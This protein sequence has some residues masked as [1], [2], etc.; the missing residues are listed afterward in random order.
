MTITLDNEPYRREVTGEERRFL[1]SPAM[2]IS[3]VLRLRGSVSEEALKN[4]VDKMLITYPLFGARM[5]WADSGVHWSTTEAAAEVP[6]KTYLRETDMSWIQVLNEEHRIP[7]RLSNGPLTRFILVKG[8][9]A[10]ELIMFCHHSISDGRSLQFALREVLLHLKDVDREPPKFTDVPPQTLKLLPDGVKMGKLR[11]VMIGRFNKK[12]DEEGRVIFDE[13]DLLNIWEAFWA[14]SEY[15]IEAIEFDE[16][17][18]QKLIEVSRKN[19]VTLNSTLNTAFVKARIDA[20]GRY[21]G[22]ALVGTAADTRERLR[23]DCS[24][25][26]GYYVGTS[27]LP[28]KYKEKASFWDNVRRYHKDIGKQLESTSVFDTALTYSSLD[29][30]IVD[31]II[32]LIVGDQFEPHQSRFTK[33]SEFAS[34]KD[35]LVAK[36]LERTEEI[37]PDII[38]TNL[39]NLGLP[40]DIPGIEIERVFFTPGSSLMMEIVLGYATAGGKLTI[41]LNYY[42][43]YVDGENTRKVRDKA[44]EIL[45]NLI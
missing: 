7:T 5:E 27:L 45:R 34:Q 40:E 24:E 30:T 15:C 23:I 36:F 37:S 8:E 3:L 20:V 14:N 11:S 39:G 44:E 10:S 21:D 18:T 32:F 22:K 25:G 41:T 43:G 17:E 38:S 42:K 2:H 13:E 1:L 29:P 35:G 19:D 6:V 33:I 26:V 12:W 16:V 9:D 4:A 28:F 31:A